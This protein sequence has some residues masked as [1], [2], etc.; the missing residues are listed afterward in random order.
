VTSFDLRKKL[1][2]VQQYTTDALFAWNVGEGMNDTSKHEMYIHQGGLTLPSRLSRPAFTGTNVMIIFFLGGG[3][4][5]RFSQNIYCQ[6][7]MHMYVLSYLQSTTA[8]YDFPT[9]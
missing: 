4:N 8:C 3:Q 2:L 1:I 6:L 7:I 5:C 9:F